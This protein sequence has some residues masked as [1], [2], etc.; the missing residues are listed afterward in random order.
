MET[1]RAD[2]QVKRPGWTKAIEKIIGQFGILDTSMHVALVFK[3]PSDIVSSY[4]G[5]ARFWFEGAN[6]GLVG[7]SFFTHG[8]TL[9]E[10]ATQRDVLRQSKKCE[11]ARAI[12]NKIVREHTINWLGRIT[13]APRNE[14]EPRYKQSTINL[15]SSISLLDFFTR[16]TT[17]LSLPP[18]QILLSITNYNYFW[19][20]Q[21]RKV[22][23]GLLHRCIIS[24][25]DN[26]S[27]N[28]IL[29]YI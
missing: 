19:I 3:S 10:P 22:S 20:T 8:P 7:I 28:I 21:N 23:R 15:W 6:S 9:C 12:R 29:N 1:I 18:I 16:T 4:F 24:D 27:L 14:T 11:D 2:H 26:I 17:A 13:L 25:S 5:H